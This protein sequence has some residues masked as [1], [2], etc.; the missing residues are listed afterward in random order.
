MDPRVSNS[1]A[2]SPHLYSV[3]WRAAR[4]KRLGPACAVVWGGVLLLLT[5]E[6]PQSVP[7]AE[8]AGLSDFAEW[9]SVLQTGGAV[10]KPTTLGS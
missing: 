8:C 4:P 7:H 1:R 10:N 2:T 3:P 5:T 6:G 9:V